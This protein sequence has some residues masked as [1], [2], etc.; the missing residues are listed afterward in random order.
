MWSHF[1]H[2]LGN[3]TRG[4]IF[5]EMC[6]INQSSVDFHCEPLLSLWLDWFIGFAPPICF[7]GGG[8]KV[9]QHNGMIQ[10]RL[11][12]VSGFCINGQCRTADGGDSMMWMNW[13]SQQSFPTWTI[14]RLNCPYKS[15]GGF[16]CLSPILSDS[17]DKIS[18]NL[19]IK[20]PSSPV[21]L[22]RFGW[23]AVDKLK[24][25]EKHDNEKEYTVHAPIC[26]RSHDLISIQTSHSPITLLRIRAECSA[27]VNYFFS[28]ILHTQILK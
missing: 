16:F 28:S 1:L 21:T 17:S 26:G 15:G 27:P 18:A 6:K 12:V 14:L 19:A 25:E 11:S 24:I 9:T 10:Y 3:Y 23:N 5:P 8:A 20:S 7:Y 13:D 2:S 4:T 22:I